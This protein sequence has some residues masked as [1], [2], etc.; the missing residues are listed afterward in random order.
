[1][2]DL[3]QISEVLNVVLIPATA[4]L[5]VYVKK[6]TPQIKESLHDIATFTVKAGAVINLIEKLSKLADNLTEAAASGDI[7]QEES[8]ALLA[9]VKGIT[10]DQA[11]MDLKN[12]IEAYK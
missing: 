11:V 4:I 2:I 1:M 12:L 7:S 9:E 6:L 10:T 3:N 8:Q 5:A